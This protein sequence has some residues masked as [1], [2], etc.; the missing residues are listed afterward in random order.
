MSTTF[1]KLKILLPIFILLGT[2]L[3]ADSLTI[4]FPKAKQTSNGIL[5]LDITNHSE[6]EIQL[7]TWNTPFETTLSA[8]IF[9]VEYKHK[10]IAYIGRRVKRSK[11]KE[12]DYITLQAGENRVVHLDLSQ[13]YDMKEEGD[14]TVSYKGYFTFKSLV[15]P[16]SSKL[17]TTTPSITLHYTPHATQKP[18]A[19]LTAQT[20]GCS[21]DEMLTLN[22]AHDNAI[23]LAKE[24]LDTIN[25]SSPNTSADR[26][27]TWFGSQDLQRH[28]TVKSHLNNIYQALNTQQITFDCS[29]QEDI[30]AYVYDTQPYKIHIC[31]HFWE[32]PISSDIDS[33][34]G[35]LIH[36]LA[37]FNVVANTEDYAYGQTDAKILAISNPQNA[38]FNSDNYEYFSENLP[39]LS[40][41]NIYQHAQTLDVLQEIPLYGSIATAN[42]KDI[43]SFTAPTS[44]MYTFSTSGSLDTQ[45]A[46]YNTNDETLAYSDDTNASLNF[47]LNYYLVAGRTYYIAINAFGPVQG[48]YTLHASLPVAKE[49]TGITHFVERFYRV[50]LGREADAGG[51][52]TWV[53]N[54]V[55]GKQ[56]GADI[57]R[58]F[59]F[60]PEFTN[61]HLNNIEYLTTLYKAFFNRDPDSAGM[62]IWLD[63]LA[64]GTPRAE[65]LDGF[66]FSKEFEILAQSFGIGANK[67]IKSFVHRFY[68]AILGR[69]SND[70]ELN[71][72]VS[73]LSTGKSAAA[74]IARGFIFSPE[75]T[76]KNTDDVQFVTTLYQ[77]FFGRL[78]DSAGFKIWID[79]LNQG[80][81]RSEILDG[82]LYSLEFKAL[83]NGYGIIAVK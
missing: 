73:D 51:L 79:K 12:N 3:M 63:K 43:F 41:D 21:Y 75:Y 37:H 30:Y 65:V 60:S 20:S 50:V 28:A 38:L 33:Q 39:F 48:A 24:S 22:Q 46:L 78:P 25:A 81:P 49:T 40:M 54:L 29:C 36:E 62:N 55:S 70:T 31:N 14:Y 2:F 17:F 13:Y 66:L 68:Q 1:Q 72:W 35:I 27:H 77:A 19:K 83:S 52:N 71:N 9:H 80:V 11:P 47:S 56:V 44:G 18:L 53:S 76:N 4:S 67:D 82:F 16:K 15:N 10:K 59:I 23:L 45:G 7:L 32:A 5:T 34:A 6:N 42:E 57:A 64:T 58:G 26:Y 69:N 61:K 74:D 8:D